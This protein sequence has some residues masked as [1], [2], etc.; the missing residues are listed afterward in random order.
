MPHYAGLGIEPRHSSA[1]ILTRRNPRIL[2][3]YEP[4][5][6]RHAARNDLLALMQLH[7][8]GAPCF[9]RAV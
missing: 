2:D 1:W 6:H 5:R 8:L 7:L 4:A 3:S 9:W